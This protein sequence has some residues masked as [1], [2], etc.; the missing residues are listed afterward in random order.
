TAGGAESS[1]EVVACCPIIG[2]AACDEVET[3][4]RKSD[5][6]WLWVPPTLILVG[7]AAFGLRQ[8]APKGGQHPN[9]ED[10]L[11]AR[12][13]A[14]CDAH[15]PA[16]GISGVFSPITAG[17]AVQVARLSGQHDAAPWDTLPTDH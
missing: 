6:R 11:D 7:F 3:L 8:I 4:G 13:E 10:R 17:E 5:G 12:T 2:T 9:A 1:V 14:V 16:G 15:T